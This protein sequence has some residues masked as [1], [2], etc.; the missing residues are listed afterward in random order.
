M[1]KKRV[2]RQNFDAVGEQRISRAR[3][4]WRD[5]DQLENKALTKN[6]L[7][8]NNIGEERVDR[9]IAKYTRA[10]SRSPA[11]SQQTPI[12]VRSHAKFRAE[13]SGMSA[14]V[15]P[16]NGRGFYNVATECLG[17]TRYRRN[18]VWH[19]EFPPGAIQLKTVIRDKPKKKGEK[20]RVI[21]Q[22]WV[23]LDFSVMVPVYLRT[24]RQMKLLELL[25]QDNQRRLY[26]TMHDLIHELG[27]KY[28]RRL[29][30]EIGKDLKRLG[31]FSH[32]ISGLFDP[33]QNKRLAQ[34]TVFNAYPI[35]ESAEEIR[36]RYRKQCQ[37]MR[38]RG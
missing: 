38:L 24:Q 2:D 12:T 30:G 31:V 32:K 11:L 23:S 7:A 25:S 5:G 14:L 34:C 28:S 13:K 36:A 10:S 29:C 17:V 9:Q 1:A 19:F 4:N 26:W 18:G 21:G 16:V 35:D 6:N 3:K 27:L 15:I 22:G 8:T 37:Q 33:R 20:G